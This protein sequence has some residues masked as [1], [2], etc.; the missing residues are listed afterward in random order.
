MNRRGRLQ[1]GLTLTLIGTIILFPFSELLIS[2]QSHPNE[3]S[4]LVIANTFVEL[5]SILAFIGVLT[6]VSLLAIGLVN[7]VMGFLSKKDWEARG[8][9]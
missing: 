2:Y 8:V 1:I 3:A 4:G 5:G 7:I 6:G 9:S